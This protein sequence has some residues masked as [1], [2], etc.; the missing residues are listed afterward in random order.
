MADGIHYT[1]RMEDRVLHKP[2]RVFWV[3]KTIHSFT[4]ASVSV[5]IEVS[6]LT[7]EA[8]L[9]ALPCF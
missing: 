2:C 1:S 4:T 6:L 9:L 7:L 8:S 5:A 3:C